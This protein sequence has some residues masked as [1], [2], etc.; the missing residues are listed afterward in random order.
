MNIPSTHWGDVL[1]PSLAWLREMAVLK[2]LCSHRMWLMSH[3]I[4]IESVTRLTFEP[5]WATQLTGISEIESDS[6]WAMNKISTSKANPDILCREKIA[7]AASRRNILKP[8]CVSAIPAVA[9]RLTKNAKQ[10][11]MSRR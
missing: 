6:R 3:S 8:H 7:D 4:R 1:E 11:P 10:R 2:F 5:G 9:N